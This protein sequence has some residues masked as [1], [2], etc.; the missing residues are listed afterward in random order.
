[1]RSMDAAA[2]ASI[3]LFIVV[4]AALNALALQLYAVRKLAWACAGERRSRYL[5]ASLFS[6]TLALL[7]GA[8]ATLG[9]MVW[10]RGGRRLGMARDICSLCSQLFAGCIALFM[11][12]QENFVQSLS[13]CCA[14]CAPRCLRVLGLIIA[15]PLFAGTAWDIY[16]IVTTRTSSAH[17]PTY[18][19]ISSLGLALLLSLAYASARPMSD[20]RHYRSMWIIL[21]LSQ[22]AGIVETVFSM[23]LAEQLI[24][25]S[26]MIVAWFVGT[27]AALHVYTKLE[28]PFSSPSASGGAVALPSTPRIVFNKD[29]FVS[30]ASA[31][32]DSYAESGR[33]HK[34]DSPI[35]PTELY[36][37]TNDPFASPPASVSMHSHQDSS[38][39][40]EFGQDKLAPLPTRAP[41]SGGRT[42]SPLTGHPVPTLLL[43]LP[44][45]R[46]HKTS[47]TFIRD[48]RNMTLDMRLSE[49][50][51]LHASRKG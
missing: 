44:R 42:R 5:S 6:I 39:D 13:M 29:R 50:S 43:P 26:W 14:L 45:H 2:A 11:F 24:L 21:A 22:A 9:I 35:T 15:L 49:V 30:P 41:S 19:I 20:K 3:I 38:E 33:V 36:M 40:L 7:V 31:Y 28:P 46:E 25:Q 47:P 8:T 1:M 12:Q 23:I 17:I 18:L 37:Y 34:A 10:L 32:T 16:S 27:I 51:T 4:A 48:T